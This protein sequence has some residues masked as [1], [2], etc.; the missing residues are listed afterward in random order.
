MEEE[1]T[2]ANGLWNTPRRN[3]ADNSESIRLGEEED[4]E[5]SS[6][7]SSDDSSSEEGGFYYESNPNM[8]V[9]ETPSAK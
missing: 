2:N 9:P 6:D 1:K 8:F 4:S 5:S 7:I 3:D